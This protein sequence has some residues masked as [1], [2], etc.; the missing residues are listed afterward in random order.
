MK[1]PISDVTA[2]DKKK[3]SIQTVHLEGGVEISGEQRTQVE[4]ASPKRAGGNA[5]AA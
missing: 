2:P 4:A 5:H 1:C 3:P